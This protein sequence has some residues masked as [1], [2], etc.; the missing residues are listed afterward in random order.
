MALPYTTSNS[1]YTVIT[2]SAFRERLEEGMR[3]PVLI[4]DNYK[5]GILKKK[6]PSV[7]TVEV[8]MKDSRIFAPS[9]FDMA[10]AIRKVGHV[11]AYDVVENPMGIEFKEAKIQ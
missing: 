1:P 7:A 2:L 6:Y 4:D 9:Y 11:N 10:E 5:I 3:V 8:E